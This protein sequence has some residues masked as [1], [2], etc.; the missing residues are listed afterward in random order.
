MDTPPHPRAPTSCHAQ[1]QSIRQCGAGSSDTF[2]A[3]CGSRAGSSGTFRAFCGSRA[4]SSGNLLAFCGS[5]AGSSRPLTGEAAP[6]T[7]GI[8][9]GSRSRGIYAHIVVFIL[10]QVHTSVNEDF[11]VLC[12]PWS[13]QTCHGIGQI[14]GVE[15]AAVGSTTFVVMVV[16]V[17]RRDYMAMHLIVAT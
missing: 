7:S 3:L 6:W 5:G 17:L 12:P 1:V 14:V 13:L 16:A 11:F 4:G 15:N 8:N 10:E 9:L 2:R